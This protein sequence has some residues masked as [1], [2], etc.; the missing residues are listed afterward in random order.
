MIDEQTA[1]SFFKALEEMEN[2]DG[3]FLNT[4]LDADLFSIEL[5][6]GRHQFIEDIKKAVSNMSDSEKMNATSFFGFAIEEGGGF[7]TLRGYPSIENLNKEDAISHAK[8]YHYVKEFVSDNEALIKNHPVTTKCLNA[9]IKT[10]PEFLTIIGKVQHKTHSY[11]VDIHTLKVLQGAMK[12]SLYKT[13]P[14]NDRRA[15]QIAI[16]MHDITKKEGEIDKSHPACSARDAS[17]ILNKIDIP[18]EEKSKICLII[19]NHDWLER[20]NKKI[21][22]AEEFANILKDGN[23]FKMLCILAEADLRAV[24]KDG[25]FYQKYANVL[26]E[27]YKEIST[28]IN[29]EVS[30]A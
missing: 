13:L 14:L 16:L 23:N 28:L 12:N 22:S 9:I 15:L 29:K 3:A 2:P 24:Q 4:N 7:S 8:V 10:F 17:F 11:T 1:H 5:Q 30:A 18:Q 25:A 27:G 19:R 26:N 6:Y 21:T 20:Y